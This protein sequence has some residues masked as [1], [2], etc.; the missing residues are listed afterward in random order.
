M[1]ASAARI[2]P[3]PLTAVAPALSGQ[4]PLSPP[5]PSPGPPK[6]S[7]A[8]SS[9]VATVLASSY[10]DAD[11]RDALA[12]L[13]GRAV[14][15][16]AE[17]RRQLRLDLQREVIDSN[18][19]I[20]D[21]FG[22]VAE[23]SFPA[24]VASL[25]VPPDIPPQQ[26]RRIGN[27]LARLNT[28]CGEMRRQITDAHDATSSLLGDAASLL[29]RRR[30][31]E[32]KQRLLRACQGRFVLSDDEAASLTLTSEPIDDAFFLALKKAKHISRDCEFLLG[33]E[34]QTL[35]NE[36]MEQ[37]SKHVN[38]AFQ[39]LYRWIQ[40]EF[41]VLNLENPQIGP[42]IR[43]ALRVLA[44]RPSLFQ[45]CMDSFA[46]AREHV[47]SDS[48][49]TALTGSS[50]SGIADASV[51]PIE[52]A[53]H[54]PLRYVGDML[55]WIHSTTVGEREALEVLFVSD[56][57]ELAREIQEARQSEVWRLVADEGETVP[58]FDAGKALDDLVDR[59]IS[60]VA[61]ILRQRVEQVVQACEETIS[62]Y[63]LANLL[64]F[65]GATFARLLRDESFLV[66]TL[67]ALESE[68]LRQ[69]KALTRDQV[70]ALQTDVQHVPPGLGPPEF[71]QETLKQLVTIM[72]TYDSS[73]A[74]SDGRE[75]G[76][77]PILAEAFDP[78]MAGCE[79][80]AGFI[81]TPDD[82]IFL[83]NCLLAAK[84]VLCPFDFASR[85]LGE[86]EGRLKAVSHS[87][88]EYQYG[89]LR[90]ES[91]VG[92]IFD[93]L[94]PLA[95]QA[96]DLGEIRALPAIQPSA[97]TQASQ[98][99]DDFLPSALMDAMEN[100][101]ELDDSRMVREI[102]EEAAER[103]CHDFEHVEDM[104]VYADGL[105]EQGDGPDDSDGERPPSLRALFPRTTGEIRVLLS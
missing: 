103:F 80:M 87:L 40:R 54:D 4:N 22:R 41:K 48:F 37:A 71:F 38:Q 34:N 79:S 20:V 92:G 53:A 49:F 21:E 66:D 14:Q 67:K 9:K 69:F 101:K 12:L 43:R 23:V 96:E 94:G 13:D 28:A 99:L 2:A 25:S 75:G 58:A 1:A 50:H 95:A 85:R 44:E 42:G 64:E 10:A 83:A 91:G 7:N 57:G 16:C 89:Y 46:D 51:K 55:A 73:L 47:L 65:Y 15:N 35:G 90:R 27:T 100:I 59:D 98:R 6:A 68:A 26:L 52:L 45:N 105:A 82:A 56:G 19:E 29:H 61:R 78:F 84:T 31:V 3:K 77:G 102:T 17:T 18:G 70:A 36:V 39:K 33:F 5:P 93:A 62:A 24:F 86:L 11:F 104:L 60:G 72:E 76:F 63:K 32:A 8:L 88:S 30:Q 81:D 74:T 97:L